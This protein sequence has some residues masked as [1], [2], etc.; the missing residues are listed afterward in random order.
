MARVA[1]N[2]RDLNLSAPEGPILLE[3]AQ[4]PEVSEGADVVEEGDIDEYDAEKQEVRPHR[5]GATPPPSGIG[6][7]KL[8]GS[9]PDRW[10]WDR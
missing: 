6:V 2:L 7:V 1:Q 8:R 10:N 9:N 4:T 3:V 5:N